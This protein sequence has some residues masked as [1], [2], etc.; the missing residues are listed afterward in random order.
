MD[1]KK[2]YVG[3]HS[4]MVKLEAATPH[5]I[6]HAG[7]GIRKGRKYSGRVVLAA[8]RGR[9]SRSASSGAQSGGPADHPHQAAPHRLRQVSPELHGRGG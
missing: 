5:G 4:P 3:E 8:M 7:L 9:K 6:Q 1:Q 2:V